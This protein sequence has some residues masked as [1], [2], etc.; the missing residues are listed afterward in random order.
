MFTRFPYNEM[1]PPTANAAATSRAYSLMIRELADRLA[2]IHRRRVNPEERAF[3]RGVLGMPTEA[4]RS[5]IGTAPAGRVLHEAYPDRYP[6]P[7]EAVAVAENLAKVFN[8]QRV[9]I[10]S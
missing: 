5:L 3:L 4:T 7:D 9:F 6:H 10:V 2:D 1:P 8:Q